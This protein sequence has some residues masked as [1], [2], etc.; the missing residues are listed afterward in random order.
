VDITH[1]TIPLL[2]GGKLT[3]VT[4]VSGFLGHHSEVAGLF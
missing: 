2:V 4:M 3:L 1:V